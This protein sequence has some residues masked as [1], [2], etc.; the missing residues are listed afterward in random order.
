MDNAAITKAVDNAYHSLL[1][2]N[3]H[4]IITLS[5]TVPSESIDVNVHPQKREIKFSQEQDIF[6]L[7]YH[8]VL[9]ALT[10]VTEAEDI[11]TEMIK[12]PGRDIMVD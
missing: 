2:K 1:P 6:R 9:N 10:S 3:G 12:N 7:T 8:A 5:L 11:S 4:P